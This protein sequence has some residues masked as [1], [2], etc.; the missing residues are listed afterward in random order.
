[1]CCG[2]E[3]KE[4]EWWKDIRLADRSVTF[5]SEKDALQF[6]ALGKE[7]V[8]PELQRMYEVVRR[9]HELLANGSKNSGR[10]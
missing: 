2:D 1:M 5:A 6:L 3:I 7:K 8:E 10:T 4:G 9:R